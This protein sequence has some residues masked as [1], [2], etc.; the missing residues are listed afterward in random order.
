MKTKANEKKV[1]KVEKPSGAFGKLGKFGAGL[2]KISLKKKDNDYQYDDRAA[3]LLYKG[4]MLKALSKNAEAV[5]CFKEVIDE[6]SE[7]LVV[8]VDFE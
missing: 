7:V 1:I 6:L 3:Y 5:E 8:S 2:S 4:S